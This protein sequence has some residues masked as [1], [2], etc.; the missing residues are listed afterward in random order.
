MSC[1]LNAEENAEMNN[2]HD[3]ELTPCSNF[4][5]M[6]SVGMCTVHMFIHLANL[7]YLECLACILKLMPHLDVQ[8]KF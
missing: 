4:W 1:C 6:W 7:K 3:T 2:Y 5:N 8:L